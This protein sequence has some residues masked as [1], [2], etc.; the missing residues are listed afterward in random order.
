MRVFKDGE[1]RARAAMSGVGASASQ[2]H[3]NLESVRAVVALTSARGGV[4]KSALAVNFA[5]ALAQSGRKVGI[6][7]ADLN[8]PSILAMLG[9]RA[10]RRPLVTEGLEP[11]AG[12]LGIRV[13]SVELLP[14]LASAPVSFLDLDDSLSAPEANRQAVVEVGYSATLRQLFEQTRWG[15]LDVLLV[16]LPPGVEAVT[17][18][19]PLAPRAGLVIL[20]H[21]SQLAARAVRTIGELATAHAIA[22]L[23]V[24][25]NMAG[26]YCEG[27]HTVRPLMPQGAVAPLAHDLGL[28][29]LERL[30][31]DPHLAETTDRGVLFVHDYPDT[32]LAKQLI[33]VA[34]S[35]EQAVKAAM[36]TRD[37]AR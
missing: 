25:E 27:C 3:A 21:P 15:A 36:T 2:L 7:D 29:V 28:P 33:A 16:D 34:Q 1:L 32:P 18:L 11:T 13:A 9:I 23:G 14:D 10:P 37:A 17:R 12:P 24:I 30:P 5:A 4:G 35:I 31:F 19:I 26:F 8:S 22:V 20:T 6:V